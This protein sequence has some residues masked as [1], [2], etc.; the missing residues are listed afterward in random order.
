LREGF[1]APAPAAAAPLAAAAAPPAAFPFSVF[2]SSAFSLATA[3]QCGAANCSAE[4]GSHAGGA[5]FLSVTEEK[6]SASSEGRPSGL[7]G[8]GLSPPALPLPP[9]CSAN[10]AASAPAF[11]SSSP[12]GPKSAASREPETAKSRIL[13]R[14]QKQSPRWWLESRQ[15]LSPNAA[16]APAPARARP[17]MACLPVT[18][19]SPSVASRDSFPPSTGVAATP[20]DALCVSVASKRVPPA[21]K[22]AMFVPE[23]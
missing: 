14:S 5:A 13:S 10:G 16:T 12:G 23:A 11:S 22:R 15:P 17:R 8:S 19:P 2:P 20:S 9:V 1:A 18:P 21:G 7:D 4:F 3:G 6:G